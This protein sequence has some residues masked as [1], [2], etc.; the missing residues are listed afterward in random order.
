MRE[1]WRGERGGRMEDEEEGK[2]KEV[3]KEDGRKSV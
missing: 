3:R 2:R 1:R